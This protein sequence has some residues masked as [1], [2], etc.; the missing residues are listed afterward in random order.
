E[1][2]VA[3]AGDDEAPRFIGEI[4]SDYE[5]RRTDEYRAAA[6]KILAR[7]KAEAAT[8]SYAQLQSL[9][10]WCNSYAEQA[11]ADDWQAIAAAIK[12]RW[13]AISRD[14]AGHPAIEQLLAESLL[15]VLGRISHDERVAFLRE[16]LA[17]SDD[18]R[19]AARASA[20]F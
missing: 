14:P 20:L 18:E 9:V 2:L 7:L 1:L 8:L 15:S 19:R 6:A 13:Q 11:T 17:A 16:S 4:A 5:V 3:H 10:A 12:P